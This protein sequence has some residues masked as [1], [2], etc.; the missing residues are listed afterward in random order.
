MATDAERRR[1]GVGIRMREERRGTGVVLRRTGSGRQR[2]GRVVGRRRRAGRRRRGSRRLAQDTQSAGLLSRLAVPAPLE[3]HR[4]RVHQVAARREHAQA[5]QVNTAVSSLPIMTTQL[6]PGIFKL[7]SFES[8][9]F[10]MLEDEEENVQTLEILV[11]RFY[12]PFKM[13]ASSKK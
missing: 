3:G 8:L 5:E 1:R 10:R 11:A 12:R 9:V 7:E 6:W 13:A 2:L 4:R